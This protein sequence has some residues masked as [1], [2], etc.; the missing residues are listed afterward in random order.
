MCKDVV[1]QKKISWKQEESQ[2]YEQWVEFIGI[3]NNFSS[4]YIKMQ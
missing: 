2:G 3:F 4:L 1:W